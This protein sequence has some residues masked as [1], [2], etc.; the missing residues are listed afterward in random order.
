[1]KFKCLKCD[2]EFESRMD[3][4]CPKCGERMKVEPVYTYAIKR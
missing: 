2:T 4:R 1:M 3:V